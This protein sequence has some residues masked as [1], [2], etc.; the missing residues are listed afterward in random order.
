M[1]ENTIKESEA[2][3]LQVTGICFFSEDC[4][5]NKLLELLRDSKETVREYD[6]ELFVGTQ[7]TL[8]VSI[9]YIMQRK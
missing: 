2:L 9:I 7:L 8:K 4:L 1:Y 3:I 6:S 5:M